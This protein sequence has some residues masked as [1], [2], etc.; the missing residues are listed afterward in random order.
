MSEI[1]LHARDLR[2]EVGGRMLVDTLTLT[3]ERGQR[4]AVIGRNGAGKTSLL[5]VLAGLASP[6]RGT[7]RYGDTPIERLASR[8]RALRRSV[9][10]QDSHDAFPASVLQT[11]LA[12]RHPHLARFAWETDG[13][14]AT[15]R[16][17][18][19]TFGLSALEARDVRTLS[20]GERRRVA[21]A[22][23]L[24]QDASLALLDEPSSH[25]DIAQQVAALESFLD[26]ARQ[27]RHAVVMVLHDLHLAARLCDH[28]IAIGDGRAVAQRADEALQADALSR[29]F[30]CPL[31]E[32]SG[33]GLRTFVPR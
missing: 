27:R 11:V 19:R 23:L 7:V 6:A 3:I 1:L 12:G 33:E 21:L 15:A 14:L 31:V 29:L 10:P 22:A 4:W 20:G 17:A 18:L 24:V 25:L 26:A 16:D 2:L 13:D 30:A 9:L 8:E 32:L 28:V 5:R